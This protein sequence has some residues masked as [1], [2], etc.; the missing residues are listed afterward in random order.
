MQRA[1]EAL[2]SAVRRNI[3]A[4]LADAELNAGEI[5]ARF[6]MSKPSISQHLSVLTSAGFVTREKRGKHVFYRQLRDNILDTLNSCAEEICPGSRP[7]KT[8]SGG[9]A[10]RGEKPE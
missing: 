6:A 5:A 10:T 1:F 3:L 7:L 8:E 2:S 4:G 9:L